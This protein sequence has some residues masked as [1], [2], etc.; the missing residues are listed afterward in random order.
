MDAGLGDVAD[1]GRDPARATVPARG[2]AP[3]EVGVKLAGAY[4]TTA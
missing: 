1:H 2:A 4:I 3:V